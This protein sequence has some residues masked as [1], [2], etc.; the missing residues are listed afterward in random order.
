MGKMLILTEER[1]RGIISESI[2][3]V[4][5]E[6]RRGESTQYKGHTIYIECYDMHD[7]S[8]YAFIKSNIDTIWAILQE[9]YSS[10]GGFKSF[11]S[12]K[13]ILERAPIVK[14]GFYDNTIVAVDVFNGY[15]GGN[16]SVGITCVKNENHE[17]GVLLVE[18]IIKENIER[19]EDWV[20]AEVSG[21]IEKLYKKYNGFQVP[22]KY[23][24][25]FLTESYELD[26]DGY[27][28]YH[29]FKNDEGKLPTEQ[30]QLRHKTIFGVKD[31]ATFEILMEDAYG[32]FLE[33]I[34]RVKSG[35][36][37]ES[38]YDRYFA[39]LS[40]V[41]QSKLIVDKIVSMVDEEGIHELPPSIYN[42]LQ[43]RIRFLKNAIESGTC[44]TNRACYIED[45][46]TSGERALSKVTLLVPLAV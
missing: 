12:K 32:P 15:K 39:K 33:F 24:E 36:L 18:M 16:K 7:E 38:V 21:K 28:Y 20:W 35:K 46:I 4:L 29:P 2:R 40:P 22:D 1:L 9:G 25:I 5:T 11:Q 45:C 17:P 44:E 3:K 23:L 42:E 34:S 6:S 14:L 10:I 27:H 13:Q 8:D 30:E 37:N 43:T 31:N 26:N 19:W 41:E